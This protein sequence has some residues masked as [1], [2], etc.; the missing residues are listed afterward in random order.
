MDVTLK[1]QIDA[2]LRGEGRA[3]RELFERYNTLLFPV[4]LRYARDRPE[5]QD[6][7]Q[8]AFLV[9][10]RDLGQYKGEG[11]LGA[12]LRR[13]TLRVAL[14]HLRRKHP[15]QHAEDYAELPPDALDFNPDTKLD[16]EAILQMV[17]QLPPGY[18][19]VFNL[20]CVEGFEY[21]EIATELGISESTVRSQYAR[22]C[23]QL[24]GLVERLLVLV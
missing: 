21:P 9:I 24:R 18:R 6:I 16:S 20:R 22:A 11:P 7:L 3:Q 14:Q 5:A 4:C 8:D 13:V 17:Q 10:F 1:K 19:T 12:W 15:L 2:C 23:K